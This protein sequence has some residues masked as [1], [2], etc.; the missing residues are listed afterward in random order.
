[1]GEHRLNSRFNQILTKLLQVLIHDVAESL[2]Y[3]V[4]VADKLMLWYVLR[5]LMVS[6]GVAL[7]LARFS[8]VSWHCYL[9]LSAL[10]MH[11][12]IR[13]LRG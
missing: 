3:L 6:H 4:V 1:M 12:G 11:G 5:S 10:V 9:A 2:L 8:G 13:Q 7:A